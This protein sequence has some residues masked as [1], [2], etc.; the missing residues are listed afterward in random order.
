MKASLELLGKLG[1]VV[2]PVKSVLT[3]SHTIT[4][5]G[6]EINS[7]QVTIT[8][9]RERKGEKIYSSASKFLN[10]GT[11]SAQTSAKFIGQVVASVPGVKFRPLWYRAFEKDKITALREGRGDYESSVALSDEAKR[12]FVVESKCLL[13]L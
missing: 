8:L 6:F 1:F 5:L 7:S 11:V 2:H 4:Y 13:C 12:N 10:I 9:T 3:P